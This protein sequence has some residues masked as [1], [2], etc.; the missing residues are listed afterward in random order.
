MYDRKLRGE[1]VSWAAEARDAYADYQDPDDPYPNGGSGGRVRSNSAAKPQ[2]RK[3]IDRYRTPVIYPDIWIAAVDERTWQAP[4]P[5]SGSPFVP[6][7]RSHGLSRA[8]ADTPRHSSPRSL[9]KHD[10]SGTRASP[11][12]KPYD[13]F[14][15]RR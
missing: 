14:K 6:A 11:G 15:D 10:E 12:Y 13:P 5:R 4:P 7:R 8:E 3:Q 9:F 2:R 1:R